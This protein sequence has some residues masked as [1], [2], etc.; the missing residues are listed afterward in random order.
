MAEKA[1]RFRVGDPMDKA[2]DMGPLVSAKQRQRVEDF[3]QAGLKEGAKLAAG[4]KRPGQLHRGYFFEPTILKDAEQDM[5]V[6]REE[7]FGRARLRGPYPEGGQTLASH[8]RRASQ[9]S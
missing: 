1:T 4:G 9:P 7:I 2:T 3:V 6:C 8:S 5:T